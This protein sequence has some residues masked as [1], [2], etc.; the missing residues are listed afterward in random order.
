MKLV[1]GILD[2]AYS[3]AQSGA[4]TTSEVAE[5]LE[6]KYH[7]METFYEA[8]K[9]QIADYLAQSVVDAVEIVV[10]SGRH[11]QPTFAGAQKIEAEFRAFLSANE[12]G[13]LGFLSDSERDYFLTHAPAYTGA[14]NAGVSHRKK[15]P[16]AAKNKAR[17][18]FIDTGLYQA[19]FRAWT[20]E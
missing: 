13:K 4:K 11:V 19:S 9:T 5:I 8:R 3:D 1:L 6:Q 20:E 14:A 18:T 12:M 7:P 17:P 2:V 15:H 16:Y 10:R